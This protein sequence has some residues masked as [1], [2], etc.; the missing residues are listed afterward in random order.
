MDKAVSAAS[1]L[2]MNGSC[3]PSVSTTKLPSS[4]SGS[5][6]ITLSSVLSPTRDGSPGCAPYQSSAAGAP[7]GGRP[8]IA[9][10]TVREPQAYGRI[11]PS[12]AKTL[13][14]LLRT[15]SDPLPTP[16]GL[17]AAASA[18]ASGAR[19]PG[20]S[21]EHSSRL[22]GSAVDI[23]FQVDDGCGGNGGAHARF[24]A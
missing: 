16:E 1:T 14:M 4:R 10:I 6:A 7:V 22:H 5:A 3:G 12:S 11:T 20:S 15:N 9:G 13:I 2:R 18:S 8:S 19:G 24:G 21:R 23:W 17:V